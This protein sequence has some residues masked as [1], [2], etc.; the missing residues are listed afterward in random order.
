MTFVTDQYVPMLFHGPI[1]KGLAPTCLVVDDRH[2]HA[3]KWSLNQRRSPRRPLINCTASES[4]NQ[5][6]PL[7]ELRELAGP[8]IHYA[9]RTENQDL[10]SLA[11]LQKLNGYPALA[12][13]HNHR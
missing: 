3:V 6:R 5:V 1:R 2:L 10:F 12:R 7:S 13:P 9:G 8:Y 11:L 4:A